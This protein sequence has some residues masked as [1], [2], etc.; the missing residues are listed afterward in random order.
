MATSIMS[1]NQLGNKKYCN[2]FV[3]GFAVWRHKS[4]KQRHIN[5]AEELD[6]KGHVKSPEVSPSDTIREWENMCTCVHNY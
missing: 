3:L 6:V 1:S 5:R 2:I 4:N